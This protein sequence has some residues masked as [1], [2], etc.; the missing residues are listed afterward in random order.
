M[1]AR[2]RL[3]SMIRTDHGPATVWSEGEVRDALDTP[4]AEVPATA[5]QASRTETGRDR[6]QVWG[7]TRRARLAVGRPARSL[8]EKSDPLPGVDLAAL[9]EEFDRMRTELAASWRQAANQLAAVRRG[10]GR[11]RRPGG[12]RPGGAPGSAGT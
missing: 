2:E 8:A 11:A 7:T 5:A 1:N 6:R 3:Q 4:A 12:R 9:V 10:V